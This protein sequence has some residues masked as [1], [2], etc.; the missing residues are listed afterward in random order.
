MK[1]EMAKCVLMLALIAV[2]VT[3]TLAGKGEDDGD[4][5]G[6][7]GK[8]PMKMFKAMTGM[9]KKMM[10]GGFGREGDKVPATGHVLIISGKVSENAQKFSIS[11]AHQ[12]EE[13][14]YE[15]S[16]VAFMFVCEFDQ[17]KIVRSSIVNG[18]RS[19]AESTENLTSNKLQPIESGGEFTICILVGDDR[20]HVS[21]DDEAFC[22]FKFK[23]PV[24]EIKAISVSGDLDNVSQLDHRLIFPMLY[25]LVNKDVPDIVFSSFIP[26][27]YKPGHVVLISGIASGNP[28]G[29]FVIMFNENGRSRQLIHLNP[30]F[31]Q[32]SVVMNT[33]L[34]DDESSWADAEVQSQIFPFEINKP[35]KISAAFT[36][37][38]LKIATNGQYVMSFSLKQIELGDDQT[39]WEILTGFQIKAGEDIKI[40]ITQVEHV[41]TEDKD[42]QGFESCSVPNIY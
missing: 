12:K 2:F 11:L 42:C 16:D 40:Q 28:E 39:I 17:G 38:D 15:N 5:F 34:D 14:P 30:R 9:M 24:S 20:F 37:S 26:K 23:M 3:A 31:D 33:M 29:E 41:E 4:S 21:I 32:Q 19:V 1:V 10:K 35:F 7:E 27:E 25:P 8:D 18:N 36:D 22:F 6:M 13:N